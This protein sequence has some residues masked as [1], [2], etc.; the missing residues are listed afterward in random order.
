MKAKK[1]QCMKCGSFTFVM[2]KGKKKDDLKESVCAKFAVVLLSER[3]RFL[4]GMCLQ[5]V[6]S[7]AAF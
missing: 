2:C 6:F 3:L 1:V 4:P 5:R 7:H